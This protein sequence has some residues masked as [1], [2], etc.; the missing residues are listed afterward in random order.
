MFLAKHQSIA[1]SE[2]FQPQEYYSSNYASAEQR[3][4]C[5]SEFGS[6]CATTILMTINDDNGGSLA[7]SKCTSSE[8]QVFGKET[9]NGGVFDY[10]C[11]VGI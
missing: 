8:L 1:V 10:Y 7:I 3:G 4:V 5:S 11:Y 2:N 9:S 6:Y